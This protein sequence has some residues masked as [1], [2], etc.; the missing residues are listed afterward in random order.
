MCYQAWTK[1]STDPSPGYV[2]SSETVLEAVRIA[3]VSTILCEL[4]EWTIETVNL[5][6]W[7]AA[8]YIAHALI[9]QVFRPTRSQSASQERASTSTAPPQG[10]QSLLPMVEL[11]NDLIEAGLVEAVVD[12]LIDQGLLSKAIQRHLEGTPTQRPSNRV[13]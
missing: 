1:M 9:T 4:V 12:R 11:V 2:P 5:Y 13:A 3:L 10:R 6:L 8:T 7:R